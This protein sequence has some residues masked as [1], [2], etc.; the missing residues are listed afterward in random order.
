MHYEMFRPLIIQGGMGAGVSNWRL[1]RAV[2]Q[3]GQL[4]VVSGTAL[5]VILVRKLQEGDP[6]G[7][8]RRAFS[9]FP[10]PA[11]A[12][13]ILNQYFIPG[14]KPV[15]KPYKTIPPASIQPGNGAVELMMLANFT[16]VLLA[17]E[18]H[19]G[20]VGINYLHKVQLPMLPSLYGA[21]LAG[22]DFVLMGAG[23]PMSIPGVL[24]QFARGE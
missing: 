19:A 14:G 8:L 23:I 24:D 6:G 2:S 15:E 13:R 17:K 22:V 7:E 21:M 20:F 10:I 18:G 5:D 9:R 3:M 11:I 12:E 16:E 1:A 4:G